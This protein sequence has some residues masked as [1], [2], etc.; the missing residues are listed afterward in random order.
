[1]DNLT[2]A[3]VPTADLLYNLIF[4]KAHRATRVFEAQ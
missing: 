3:D 2:A 1:M 4:K